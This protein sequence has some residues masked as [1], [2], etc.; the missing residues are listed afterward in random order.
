MS[1]VLIYNQAGKE[2]KTSFNIA[3]R[4]G[5]ETGLVKH[6]KYRT[7]VLKKIKLLKAFTI[8][9]IIKIIQNFKILKLFLLRLSPC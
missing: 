1:A 3:V 6:C 8:I 5:F 4:T 9:Q 2:C 7:S